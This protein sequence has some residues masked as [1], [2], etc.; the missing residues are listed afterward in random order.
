M[1][2]LEITIFSNLRGVRLADEHFSETGHKI[3]HIMER[4]FE[5]KRKIFYNSIFKCTQCDFESHS[6]KEK[7][8]WRA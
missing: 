3:S 5:G 6:F 8:I 2:N 4:T 7:E 1:E